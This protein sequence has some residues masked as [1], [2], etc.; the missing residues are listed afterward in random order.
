MYTDYDL[1]I[2][3]YENLRY[4]FQNQFMQVENT[5]REKMKEICKSENGVIYSEDM[6][7][8]LHLAKATDEDMELLDTMLQKYISSQQESG[9]TLYRFGPT[10]MR[11]YYHLDQPKFAVES[12]MNPLYKDTY[13]YRVAYRILICLLYKHKMFNEAKYTFEHIMKTK[14][15]EYIGTSMIIMFGMCMVEVITSFFS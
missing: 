6:K 7:A 3:N 4:S 2:Q 1:R 5:F 13:N 9:F 12:F 11:M 15:V 8:M 14:G 10:L